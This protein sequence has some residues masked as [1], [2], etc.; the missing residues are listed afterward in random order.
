MERD[1][2][3]MMASGIQTVNLAIQHVGEHRQRNPVV[4]MISRKRDSNAMERQTVGNVRVVID[5]NFVVKIDK[6]K[7]PRLTE[8]DPDDQDK[9]SAD[10]EKQ[11]GIVRSYRLRAADFFRKRAGRGTL[12]LLWF[13]PGFHQDLEQ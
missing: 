7:L 10:T 13:A 11:P 2:R 3:Q 5:I 12:C 4:Y 1:I 9:E 8:N 6:I